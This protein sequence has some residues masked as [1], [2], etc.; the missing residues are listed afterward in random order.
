MKASSAVTKCRTRVICVDRLDARELF[1][2]LSRSVALWLLQSQRSQ[3]S[4]FDPETGTLVVL[5]LAG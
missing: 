2:A 1:L 3:S 5:S 4:G